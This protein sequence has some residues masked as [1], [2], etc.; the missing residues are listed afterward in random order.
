MEWSDVIIDEWLLFFL[1][2]HLTLNQM[3]VLFVYLF[4]PVGTLEKLETDVKLLNL[5]NNSVSSR[6]WST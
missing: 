3:I 1:L 2:I 4:I 6:L 5:A